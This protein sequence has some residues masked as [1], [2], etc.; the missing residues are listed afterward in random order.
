VGEEAG[1]LKARHQAIEDF[2]GMYFLGQ[3]TSTGQELRPERGPDGQL[4]EVRPASR[5]APGLAQVLRAYWHATAEDVQLGPVDYACLAKW[6]WEKLVM[7]DRT[8]RIRDADY[9]ARNRALY[10]IEERDS[11]GVTRW[12]QRLVG[13]H[14]GYADL[15]Q[16]MK[17]KFTDQYEACFDLDTWT[18]VMETFDLLWTLHTTPESLMTEPE[19]DDELGELGDEDLKLIEDCVQEPE[20]MSLRC[21]G[22]GGLYVVKG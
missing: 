2:V 11:E 10:L 18:V 14:S 8:P 16:V 7:D 4:Q 15:Y 1:E 22:K 20:A 12:Q 21:S 6:L 17:T 9:R 5:R 3:A 13:Q 19:E